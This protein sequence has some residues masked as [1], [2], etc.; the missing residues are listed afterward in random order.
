MLTRIIA[1]LH[2]IFRLISEN[3]ILICDVLD[4]SNSLGCEICLILIDQ[5][6]AFDRV[7]DQYLWQR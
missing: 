7:E 2:N 5:E 4:L 1:L 3:I 6:K